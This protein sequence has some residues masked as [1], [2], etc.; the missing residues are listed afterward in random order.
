MFKKFREQN[1]LSKWEL[2]GRSG[3]GYLTVDRCERFDHVPGPEIQAKLAAILQTTSEKL[4]PK[5][6]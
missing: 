3:V 2:A 5:A 1:G 6:K 4:F